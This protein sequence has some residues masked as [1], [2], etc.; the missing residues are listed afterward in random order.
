MT[1]GGREG[2]SAPTATGASDRPVRPILYDP[3]SLREAVASV[4]LSHPAGCPCVV[5]HANGDE[6]AFARLMLILER[7]S[8]H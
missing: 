6:R 5:C 3:F 2:E 8:D 1:P 4:A 7:S